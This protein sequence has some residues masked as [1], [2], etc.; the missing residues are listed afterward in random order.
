MAAQRGKRILG[1]IQKA[2][3]FLAARLVVVRLGRRYGIGAGAAA[4]RGAI[5]P[6]GNTE[7]LTGLQ[8]HDPIHLPAAEQ[9]P[10]D[11]LPAAEE[12]QFVDKGRHQAM[13]DVEI[14]ASLVF[15]PIE[16]IVGAGVAGSQVDEL[17]PGVGTEYGITLRK[18]LFP[19]QLPRL[20]SRICGWLEVVDAG[21]GLENAPLLEVEIG[22]AP[23]CAT[24]TL[25]SRA[26]S[27]V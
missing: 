20:V 11:P 14:A 18:A 6:R 23:V 26:P 15:I 4:A 17:R 21:E 24:V 16:G 8:R 1:K 7:R 19:A 27:S 2:E 9:Q 5:L 12:G 22:R 25:E 13:R 10:L 3:P